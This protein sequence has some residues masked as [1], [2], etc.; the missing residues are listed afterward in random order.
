MLTI[1]P[2]QLCQLPDLH[3]LDLSQ[4]NISG[5]IPN[6]LVNLEAMKN[7]GERRF[8]GIEE[9]PRDEFLILNVKGRQYEYSERL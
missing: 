8:W 9:L 4:N 7:N 1:Y 2:E 6:C 5:P 3:I